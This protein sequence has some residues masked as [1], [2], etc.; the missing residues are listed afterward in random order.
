M[1]ELVRHYCDYPSCDKSFRRAEHLRRHQLNRTYLSSRIPI[2]PR[3]SP[4]YIDT[5]RTILC[6]KCDR[7]FYRNDLLQRHLTLKHRRSPKKTVAFQDQGLHGD[8]LP[9]RATANVSDENFPSNLSPGSLSRHDHGLQDPQIPQADSSISPSS[10]LS[11]D[12][13]NILLVQEPP[14]FHP[15]PLESNGQTYE[16]MYQPQPETTSVTGNLTLGANVEDLSQH[17]VSHYDFVPALRVD[18]YRLRMATFL[19]LEYSRSST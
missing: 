11:S 6:P 17:T 1:A 12:P 19:N 13:P 14:P 18:T 8:G 15:F 16:W 5:N 9:D 7:I 2:I 4:R 10:S 3:S